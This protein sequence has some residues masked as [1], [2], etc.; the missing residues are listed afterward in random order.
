LWKKTH[1]EDL[2]TIQSLHDVYNQSKAQLL[3]AAATRE[4]ALRARQAKLEINPPKP[5]NIVLSYWNI[6]TDVS[7]KGGSK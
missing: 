1:P 2:A 3:A 7:E 5:G 4:H 6:G